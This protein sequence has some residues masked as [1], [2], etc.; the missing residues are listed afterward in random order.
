MTPEERAAHK[1]F[2]DAQFKP[3]DSQ[4]PATGDG[5]R[6]IAPEDELR[7]A[8]PNFWR[9]QCSREAETSNWLRLQ[10][11]ERTAQC[12]Q[13]AHHVSA[14]VHEAVKAERDACAAIVDR[15][16]DAREWL[17]E[18]DRAFVRMLS[19]R[20]RSRSLVSA[21]MLKEKNDAR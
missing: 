15:E 9:D 10:L 16:T 8:P 7:R 14:A 5:A 12:E 13:L 17:R 18:S 11:A 4:R 19:K 20:M 1:A 3:V 21:E 6:E 2:I